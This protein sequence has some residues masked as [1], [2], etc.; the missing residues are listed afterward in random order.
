MCRRLSSSEDKA[1]V[2]SSSS[3]SSSQSSST[4]SPTRIT[5]FP[6][7]LSCTHCLFPIATAAPLVS[8]C[9]LPCCHQSLSSPLA[10]PLGSP[11]VPISSLLL[12][13]PSSTQTGHPRSHPRTLT[14]NPSLCHRYDFLVRLFGTDLLFSNFFT[15]FIIHLGL[16]TTPMLLMFT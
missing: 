3:L 11:S 1:R 8:C 4:L 15:L 6:P 13:Q 7:H 5:S 16:I 12:R 10:I 14:F 2:L 9:L